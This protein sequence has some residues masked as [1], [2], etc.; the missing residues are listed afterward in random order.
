MNFFKLALIGCFCMAQPAGAESLMDVYKHLHANPELSNMENET[1]N[2]LADKMDNLGFEVHRGFGGTG[3]VSVLKNG[4]GKTIMVRADMDG[5]PVLETTGLSF[6]SK[7]VKKD[8]FGDLYPVMH[9]CGHDVHMTTFLGTAIEMIN[10]QDK[11]SGTLI[12]IL[13]PAEEISHGAKDM[14]KYGL[15]EKFP[16]P[17]YNLALHVNSAMPAG[18]VGITSGYAL[19][20]VD[21]VDITVKG[22]GG[23]G[24]YPQTTKDP[25]VLASQIVLA[26]QTIVAREVDAQDSAVV[27]VG[28]IHGG[29]K[30]N[31]I[32]EQVKLQ[33]TVRSYSDET[34]NMLLNSIRRIAENMGRV[35]GL[36]ID[37]LPVV[38][39]QN[40]YTPAT[41]N[42]PKLS[43]KAI[44]FM[45][46]VIGNENVLST[47]PVMGGED[48]GRYGR[49][50]EKVPGLI[51][52]LGAA[53]P[54]E[55][56]NARQEGRQMPSLHSPF[57]KPNSTIAIPVGV[58]TMTKTVTSLF[59]E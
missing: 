13:Q 15:F 2:Y 12:M 45:S 8:R 40:E 51:Y 27:T 25:I 39:L 23:H 56:E 50:S 49:T 33:L 37:K 11:W 18:T 20:N 24:A 14:L 30:H 29:A 31:I 53:D 58:K 46:E 34:R 5:L 10:N 6:A 28:S 41:F 38:E 43:S 59:N 57:F 48:F 32:G 47:P 1:A 7:V 17:E 21:S 54:V 22:I 35:A 16:V 9:A 3:V 19:A 26:L 4:P 55:F 36:P 42:D 52:W 44:N